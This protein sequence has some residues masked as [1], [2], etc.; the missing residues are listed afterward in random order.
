V[1]TLNNL[2]IAG[3]T[4]TNELF[5]TNRIGIGTD[6]EEH[7]FMVNEKVDPAL[8]D[9]PQFF[10]TATGGVGI[11]TT[12]ELANISINAHECGA[13]FGAIGV[14]STIVLGGVDLRTAGRPSNNATDRFMLP[15]QVNST[16]RS[17]L[18]G[19]IAGA[20]IYNTSTNKL[21]VFNGSTWQNC[22]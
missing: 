9:S 22:N 10:V 1:S 8:D 12:S 14:G 5:A 11:K 19:V 13:V 3:V 7:V 2:T 20:V 17:N 15:P 18:V 16:Q 6:S 21:Q 4:T